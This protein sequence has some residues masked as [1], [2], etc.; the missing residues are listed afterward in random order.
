MEND[1]AKVSYQNI[2]IGPGIVSSG[3]KIL[4][5]TYLTCNVILYSNVILLYGDK[6]DYF[7]TIVQM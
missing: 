7:N 6:F 2:K 4:P 1:S 3:S 5:Q